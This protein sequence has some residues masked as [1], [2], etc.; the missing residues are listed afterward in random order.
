MS[1]PLLALL[2]V[3]SLNRRRAVWRD[4]RG[5]QYDRRDLE[6][7]QFQDQIAAAEASNVIVLKHEL[8]CAFDRRMQVIRRYNAGPADCVGGASISIPAAMYS[9]AAVASFAFAFARKSSADR[10]DDGQTEQQALVTASPRPPGATIHATPRRP[11]APFAAL[12]L[13]Q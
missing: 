4:Q 3:Q 12:R 9:A 2:T 10:F 13:N 5:Q 1:L 8:Q 11:G 6:R 7:A